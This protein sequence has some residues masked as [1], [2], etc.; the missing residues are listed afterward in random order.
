MLYSFLHVQINII[1]ANQIIQTCLWP[2]SLYKVD[3]II[4]DVSLDD[5]LVLTSHSGAA[6]EV[7]GKGLG[8][9]LQVHTWREGGRE[10]EE[11]TN[12]LSH[13]RRLVKCSVLSSIRNSLN[14]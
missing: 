9:L 2:F 11:G 1:S 7:L 14:H 4:T 8:G 10:E 5:D 12:C 3:D 6:G 13:F